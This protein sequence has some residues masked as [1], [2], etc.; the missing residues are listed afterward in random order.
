MRA[1]IV[2]VIIAV[3]ALALFIMPFL[4]PA[5]APSGQLE[6]SLAKLSLTSNGGLAGEWI[7]VELNLTGIMAPGS[8]YSVNGS[9]SYEK[10]DLK[11]QVEVVYQNAEN[12]VINYVRIMAEDYLD[13]SYYTYTLASNIPVDD[14]VYDNLFYVSTSISTHLEDVSAD[15]DPDGYYWVTYWV[16]VKVSGVGSYSGDPLVAFINY[17]W[18]NTYYY[19][20]VTLNG[21][22]PGSL[23]WVLWGTSTTGL[24]VLAALAFW[25]ARR[26]MRIRRGRR[27]AR[28]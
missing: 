22:P 13:K 23:S 18:F 5:L 9:G 17:T 3:L 21:G 10:M 14:P 11:C 20:E 6:Q 25:W 8:S 2:A 19:R 7:S 24:V 1:W 15:P 27:G 16:S 26:A 28:A 12:V 4:A